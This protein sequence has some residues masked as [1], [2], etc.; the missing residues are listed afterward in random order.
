MWNPEGCEIVDHD[1]D[2]NMAICQCQQLGIFAIITDMYDPDVSRPIIYSL[3]RGRRFIVL[4][5]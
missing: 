1:R 5:Q 2:A 3:F 4:I